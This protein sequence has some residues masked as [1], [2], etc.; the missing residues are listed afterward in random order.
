MRVMN[1]TRPNTVNSEEKT[2]GTGSAG[3]KLE[4]EIEMTDWL[5]QHVHVR[6]GGANG[7]SRLDFLYS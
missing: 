1:T 7:F 2:S 3:R 6:E 4:R 5:G